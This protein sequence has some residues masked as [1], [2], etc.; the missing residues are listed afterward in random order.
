MM[1]MRLNVE[2]DGIDEFGKAM[3]DLNEAYKN[4]TYAITRVRMLCPEVKVVIE[5]STADA[6]NSAEEG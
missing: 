4:L 1:A 5:N 3:N 2:L 6:D